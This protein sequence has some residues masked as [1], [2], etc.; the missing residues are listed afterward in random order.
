MY[1]VCR[2]CVHARTD[3]S[4]CLCIKHLGAWLSVSYQPLSAALTVSNFAL[5]SK[6][7]I[8][9]PY[10]KNMRNSRVRAADLSA[11]GTYN[12][13]DMVPLDSKIDMRTYNIQRP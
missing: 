10:L 12:L 8:I 3:V 9:I 4:V 11:L 2:W 1:N 6:S 5:T 13:T 7:T